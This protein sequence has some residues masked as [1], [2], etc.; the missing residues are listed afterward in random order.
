MRRQATIGTQQYHD[1]ALIH[2]GDEPTRTSIRTWALEKKI[3]VVVWTDLPGDFEKKTGKAFSL[4]AACAHLQGLSPEGKA[5][6]AEYVWR[7]PDLVVTPLRQRL[8][9]EPW[10]QPTQNQQ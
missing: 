3:D 4:D 1:A 8:Q 10:F 5:K 2:L 7:A 6:A 9:Q